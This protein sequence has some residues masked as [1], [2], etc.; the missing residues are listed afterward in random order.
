VT[1]PLLR[2]REPA[3]VAVSIKIVLNRAE[4][5]WGAGGYVAMPPLARDFQNKRIENKPPVLHGVK[6]QGDTRKC[7]REGLRRGQTQV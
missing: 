7:W 2:A 5:Q 1:S 6:E 3:G 4:T